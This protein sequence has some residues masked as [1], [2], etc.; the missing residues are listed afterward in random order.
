MNRIKY[1]IMTAALSISAAAC[2]SAPSNESAS[3]DEQELSSNESPQ[4]P[5][6]WNFIGNAQF[7]NDSADISISAD[8]V[9]IEWCNR[10]ASISPNIG[11]V[12]RV[13]PGCPLPPNAATVNECTADANFVCGAIVQPAW[14]CRQGHTCPPG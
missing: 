9:F 5:Q 7:N 6:N 10:P 1:C 12:C 3:L 2:V 4:L 11:T 8:C 13:R 14:I